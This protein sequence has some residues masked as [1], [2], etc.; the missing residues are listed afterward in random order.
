[1]I[2]ADSPFGAL[3]KVWP[4]TLLVGCCVLL[5][6]ALV[7]AISRWNTPTSEIHLPSAQDRERVLRR[8]HL[9]Y[10]QWRSQSLQGA[11]QM[12][13]GL[14]ERPAAIYNAASL[15]LRLPKQPEQ[16]LPAH[17]SIVDVYERYAQQEL[18]ILGEPGAGKS[19]LLLELATQLVKQAEQNTM[20]P[21]P[22]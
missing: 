22:V 5:F 11:I 20:Q 1:M 14:V 8:L 3:M 4:M 18:L 17:T 19:T 7:W 13:L 9:Y 15:A 6:A 2:P 12:D 21:L 16:K 10:E